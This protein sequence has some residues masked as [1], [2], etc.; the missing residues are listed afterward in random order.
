MNVNPPKKWSSKKNRL[1]VKQNG[2]IDYDVAAFNTYLNQIRSS[3]QNFIRSVAYDQFQKIMGSANL[4]KDVKMFQELED[5]LP[6]S[7][8]TG[9][10]MGSLVK[11]ILVNG[12]VTLG[13]Q[14]NISK[15]E[16]IENLEKGLVFW[17][18]VL[19]VNSTI[20]Q[21]EPHKNSPLERAFGEASQL[22]YDSFRR[23]PQSNSAK[24]EVSLTKI[25][26]FIDAAKSEEN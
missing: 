14:F 12:G 22:L 15:G 2:A 25:K 10:F 19:T 21:K 4:E 1:R 18:I 5:L 3:L 23:L 26:E 20:S 9:A 11:D 6:F 7:K 24:I 13:D 16:V 17:T 8:F